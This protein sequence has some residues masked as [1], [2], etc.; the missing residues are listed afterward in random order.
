[1][2][3][4]PRMQ[5]LVEQA[6]AALRALPPERQN[7]LAEAVLQAAANWTPRAYTAE[8]L[9]A[10][11]QGLADADAGRFVSDDELAKTMA[12]FDKE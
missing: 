5:S 6:V 9:A 8:Q 2:R 10:I 3:Y 4:I 7:E 12:L 1:M 11:D